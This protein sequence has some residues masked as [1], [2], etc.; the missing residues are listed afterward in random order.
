M[1]HRTIW[2]SCLSCTLAVTIAAGPVQ[3]PNPS[4]EQTP[5]QQAPGRDP[6]PGQQDRATATSSSNESF[7]NKAIE[8]NAAEVQ[9]GNL[10]ASK[11]QNQ[12]VKEYANML[13][14]DHSQALEKLQQ[15]QSGGGTAQSTTSP[16]PSGV[17]TRETSRGQSGTTAQGGVTT[18]QRGTTTGQAGTS[19]SQSGAATRESSRGQSGTTTAQSATTTAQRNTSTGHAADVKLSSEHEMLKTRLSGLSGAQFDREYIEAMVAGHREAIG[20]F[21]KQIGTDTTAS[22]SN[23]GASTARESTTARP[24]TDVNQVARELLPTIKKHLEQAEQ[25]QKSLSAPAK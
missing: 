10:A 19:T 8:I 2:A 15:A 21:E 6:A 5:A 14:K 3:N 7:L 24:D 12:R 20:L 1:S 17:S 4:R 25:I 9:L 11:G 23:R 22:S 16:G 13:V 18:T